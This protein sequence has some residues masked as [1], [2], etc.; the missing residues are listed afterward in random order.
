MLL[1]FV[2]PVLLGTILSMEGI[3]GSSKSLSACRLLYRDWKVYK[4]RIISWTHLNF[5]YTKFDPKWF[6]EH[7]NDHEMEDCTLFLDES[8]ILLDSRTSGSKINKLFTYFIVQTR[9]RG[10]DLV[11]AT[12]HL[13]I[14][15]KRLRRAVDIRGT[16]NYFKEK[17]CR[18]CLDTPTF[19]K[20]G[21][22]VC[23]ECRGWQKDPVFDEVCKT[24]GG[25]G[26]GPL[27]PKCL[28]YTEKNGPTEEM[29][30]TGTARVS[31]FNRRTLKHSFMRLHG[32]R[33]FWA[34]DTEERVPFL[35]KQMKI[36]LEDL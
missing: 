3:Q 23:T 4:K 6:L 16:C 34:Y 25:T 5:P 32:P 14:L 31:F 10:V 18:A 12:H 24:C 35:Q 28:G 8:Y 30:V 11:V 36:S 27:C 33:W 19:A 1:H 15:D 22:G 21:K 17:P 9:K 13:D 29:A 2:L 20:N 7:I 26:E